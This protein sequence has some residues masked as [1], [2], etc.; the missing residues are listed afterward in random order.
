MDMKWPR[1]WWLALVALVAVG[2]GGA[3]LKEGG[4]VI[5]VDGAAREA[6]GHYVPFVVWFNFVAG[7]AYVAAGV[8]LWRRRRWAVWLSFAVAVATLMVF[9][10]LGVHV[11]TGGAYELRTVGAMTLR[12][13][14][15]LAIGFLARRAIGPDKA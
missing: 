8:G 11:L 9:A 14:L 6:A 3:T 15:W 5:F 7:F 12:A 13:S 10:A 4:S 1:P 2:F